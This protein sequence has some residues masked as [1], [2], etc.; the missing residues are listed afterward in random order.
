LL[1]HLNKLGE[2]RV[3]AVMSA[4]GHILAAGI[5]FMH[6]L[7]F[8]QPLLSI[9]TTLS[10][11]ESHWSRNSLF[12]YVK[13]ELMSKGIREFYSSEKTKVILHEF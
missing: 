11:I 6:P 7:Q 12:Q 5:L 13:A 8:E 10:V 3:F 4:E 9:S 2:I 1:I